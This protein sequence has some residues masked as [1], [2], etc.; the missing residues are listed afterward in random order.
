M[1]M[2]SAHK[3]A[4]CSVRVCLHLQCTFVIALSDV[5]VFGVGE[6]VNKEE[7]NALASKKRREQH[8]FTLQSFTALGNMFNSII[9]KW[10]N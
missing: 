7:L 9:S 2:K 8:F 10:K 1:I 3:V 4:V 6:Q 5:Y